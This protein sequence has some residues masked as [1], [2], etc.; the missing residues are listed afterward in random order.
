[1]TKTLG[2]MTDRLLAALVPKTTAGACPCGDSYCTP[3]GCSGG[4]VHKCRDSCDCKRQSCTPCLVN[5]C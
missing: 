2:R 4:K 5:G 1:M 3:S